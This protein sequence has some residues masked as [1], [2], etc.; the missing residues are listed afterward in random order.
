ML[1]TVGKGKEGLMPVCIA[2]LR[3]RLCMFFYLQ[4]SVDKGMASSRQA[5][6]SFWDS[7]FGRV[8]AR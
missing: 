2:A 6:G 3:E 5:F 8:E 4:Q 1:G 7:S